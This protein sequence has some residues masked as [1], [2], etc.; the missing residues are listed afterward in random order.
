M[1]KRQM[2]IIMELSITLL[3]FGAIIAYAYGDV[4]GKPYLEKYYV[5]KKYL[6]YCCCGLITST[7]LFFI[8]LKITKRNMLLLAY[9][10]GGIG[11]LL[12]VFPSGNGLILKYGDL[13]YVNFF[14][15]KEKLISINTILL[16]FLLLIIN[17]L[18]QEKRKQEFLVI[19]MINL[20]FSFLIAYNGNRG[21]IF[22]AHI[23]FA[24]LLIYISK[25]YSEKYRTVILLVSILL[26]GG[27]HFYYMIRSGFNLGVWIN[28]FL[29]PYG[30][31]YMKIQD[32][33]ILKSARIF[34]R[35]PY[36][37]RYSGEILPAILISYGWIALLLVLV[38]FFS[39]IFVMFHLAHRIS[40]IFRRKM[41]FSITIYFLIKAIFCIFVFLNI[42]PF[43]NGDH[44]P[45]IGNDAKIV[46]DLILM[47]LYCRSYYENEQK[48]KISA[49]TGR[50]IILKDFKSFYDR[51]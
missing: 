8:S 26:I 22:A 37:S 11:F 42:L 51:R 32:F 39:L 20:F 50:I 44:F 6:L 23:L 33:H 12:N 49:K 17:D 10:I 47:G 29:D 21:E 4:S 43:Y 25:E 38:V 34:G 31:G 35:L 14:I 13:K 30:I 28:P 40:A 16:L 48:E 27:F 3:I 46:I 45:F 19:S 7:L 1:K 5:I 2:M 24:I 9:I 41:A 18:F 15:V 36:S